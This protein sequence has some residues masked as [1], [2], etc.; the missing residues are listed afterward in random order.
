MTNDLPFIICCQRSQ[1]TRRSLY[2]SVSCKF[3]DVR[4]ERTKSHQRLNIRATEFRLTDAE[5]SLERCV[6]DFSGTLAEG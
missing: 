5:G 4:E 2:L 3:I 6:A 1:D